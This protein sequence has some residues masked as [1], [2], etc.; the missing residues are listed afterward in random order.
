MRKNSWRLSLNESN[1]QYGTYPLYT[2]YLQHEHLH[3][4]LEQLF[5]DSGAEVRGYT[6]AVSGD[7]MVDDW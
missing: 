6:L 3:A 1:R 4:T 5:L 2:A 7:A